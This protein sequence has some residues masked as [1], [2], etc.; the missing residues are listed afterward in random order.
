M[1]IN[2]PTVTPDELPAI[3]ETAE[4]KEHLPAIVTD[5]IIRAGDDGSGAMNF[6]AR[7]LDARTRYLKALV[8]RLASGGIILKGHLDTDEE[9]AAIPTEGLQVGTAYFLNFSLRVWNGTEWADSGS[10]RGERGINL[11]GVWPD[12]L[13]LPTID[14]N[15]IGDAYIWKNDIHVLTPSKT[16]VKA[17]EALGIRGP[18]GKDTYTIWTEQPGNAGKPISEFLAAQKGDKGDPGDDAFKTWQKEPGNEDKTFAD[19]LL[20]IRGLKGDPGKN[21]AVLGVVA[22]RTE[23]DTMPKDDQAAWVLN[24]TGHLW[25]YIT[26][27]TAWVDLGLFRGKNGTNGTDGKNVIIKGAFDTVALLPATGNTEQDCYS[28]R[29]NNTVYMWI[30]DVWVSLGKFKGTDGTPGTNGVS[31]VLK[32]AFDTRPELPT[33]AKEQDIW[34]VRADNTINGWINA[35]WVI[36]GSFKGD[37]GVDGKN[38]VEVWLADPA[39]EGKTEEDYWI[40]QKGPKGD[41]GKNLQIKGTVADETELRAI[42]NPA[43][44]DA[45]VVDATH[46]LWVW[47]DAGGG[48]KDLGPFKGED[49]KSAY[50]NW[51]DLG[52]SGSEQ[53]F[54]TSLKGKD[55]QSLILRGVVAT[56]A[57]LP[58]NPQDQWIYA[59]QDENNLYGYVSGAWL[60][61]GGFK[62]ADGKD[63]KSIDIIKILTPED[64]TPPVADASTKGKAYIDLDKIIWVNVTSAWESAGRWAG[65]GGDPG[66]PGTPLKMLGVIASVSEL[67]A[68]ANS[69]EGDAW[70][71]ADTK[72]VYVLI[73]GQWSAPYDFIGPQGKDGLKGDP[74]PAVTIKDEYVD[75]AALKAAHPT[76]VLGDAYLLGGTGNLAIWSTTLNDWKDVG[77]FRGPQGKEGPPG[78]GLPGKPGVPGPQGSRW[79]TLPPGVDAPSDSFSGRVG[80]WAVS[81]SFNVF[82]KTADQGWVLWGRLVAGDVNSPLESAG[83]VARFGTKWVPLP[84]AEVPGMVAGKFYVRSLIEDDTN[85]HGE[86][87]ELVFP[88]Q[89]EEP[90]ADGNPYL[91]LRLNGQ[92]LGAWSKFTPP[93]LE[94]L[95]GVARTELGVSVATLVDGFVPASQLP[96]YVDDVLEFDNRAAFPA[97]GEKGKIYIADDTNVQYRWSGT[98]YVALVASPGTSD[99]VVEGSVNLY[100]T[101]PRVRGSLLTGLSTATGGTIVPGDTFITAFGKIQ[102]QLNAFVP[103]F[104][105]VPTDTNLYLRKGDHTWSLYT[106][107]TPGISAPA[108]DGKTYVYKGT[109]W[110]AFD[111][112]DLAI[113]NLSATG[114]IDP[115]A[116]LFALINNA[117]ATA[118]TITLVDGP[119]GANARA[120][121]VVVKINGI[122]G[123]ITFAPSGS[124]ALVWNG[125]APPTLSGSRTILTFLWDGVEWTGGSG[126]VVP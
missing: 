78:E 29:E 31:L 106:A 25:I 123:A 91:R 76:G 100:F 122:A 33:D 26:A 58:A 20:A 113:L 9:L 93:T 54:L 51:L 23:L 75:I 44:Q 1:A 7:A 103:G 96:S 17:W 72:F 18:D 14:Q 61:M 11:L 120:L 125:G 68:V 41:G 40:A 126:A 73:E 45:Y 71:T 105:D 87:S 32:G 118:K 64:P 114:S 62:G 43:D 47:S 48:W 46:R 101:A 116:Y 15:E 82:Y 21:L 49:G 13:S 4:W 50:Q 99:A 35:Q 42:P 8:E 22:D 107:P 84:V 81:W 115:N 65:P 5:V 69:E 28:V 74:G 112:Y 124:T 53:A 34:A 79:L 37:R 94:S 121:T 119:K 86:W 77:P 66:K 83:I 3:V 88:P 63:G 12:N 24:D 16:E 117:S 97:T 102:A 80:D 110:S 39:N 30:V 92:L 59:V 27:Q 6:Q 108:N 67:P 52:N 95:G 36:L 55:G 56:F 85:N 2:D 104:A 19:Y 10:L 109:G 38:S 111:R 60:K 98:T 90:P 57:D 70:Q 89:I